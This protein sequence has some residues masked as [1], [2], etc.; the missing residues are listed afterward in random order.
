MDTLYKKN[1]FSL[2][3]KRRVGR[4]RRVAVRARA[5]RR[6]APLVVPAGR[7]RPHRLTQ[8][9]LGR[10]LAGGQL[11]GHVRHLVEVRRKFL[12]ARDRHRRP[13]RA[14]HLVGQLDPLLQR[15]LPV[16]ALDDGGEPGDAVGVERVLALGGGVR[17]G[18]L[19][20]VVA[21]RVGEAA[22]AQEPQVALLA[23]G[24][25]VLLLLRLGVVF[26]DGNVTTEATTKKN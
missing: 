4:R 1:D 11:A 17:V 26:A 14:P 2:T 7:L 19:V 13:P 25:L 10:R 22:R 6:H 12:A 21:T 15:Q 5:Q 8:V 24:F 20:A 9:L 18:G 23:G 16:L 3:L